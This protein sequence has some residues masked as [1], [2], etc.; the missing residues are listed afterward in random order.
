MRGRPSWPGRPPEP[1]RRNRSRQRSMPRPAAL[2]RLDAH[3]TSTKST[4]ASDR[5]AIVGKWCWTAPG[6]ILAAAATLRTVR[7]AVN[8]TDPSWTSRSQAAS[9]IRARAA[10]PGRVARWSPPLPLL[11]GRSWRVTVARHPD[12]Q[13]WTPVRRPLD[14]SQ[15]SGGSTRSRQRVDDRGDLKAGQPRPQA[16]VRSV[17]VDC[18]RHVEAERVGELGSIAVSGRPP[19]RHPVPG[20]DQLAVH[21]DV[22]GGGPTVVPESRTPSGASPR[23]PGRSDRSSRSLTQSSGRA[24]SAATPTAIV[25]RVVSVPAAT[26]SENSS[27]SSSGCRRRRPRGGLVVDLAVDRSRQEVAGSSRRAS[28]NVVPYSEHRGAGRDGTI[29]GPSEVVVVVVEGGVGPSD[30]AGPVLL[31]TPINDAAPAA[32]AR[33]PRA[34]AGRPRPLPPSGSAAATMPSDRLRMSARAIGSHE[35]TA[36]WEKGPEPLVV[37]VVGHVEQH[38]RSRRAGPR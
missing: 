20:P 2:D 18:L 12:R 25:L 38:T 10:R 22:D 8:G 32:A 4:M 37:R 15:L 16:E 31:G 13:V 1:P 34:P 3:P 29:R 24:A 7:P 21:I 30:E 36:Q 26:S 17:N 35:V 28:I 19:Q 23:P 6:D 33:Q 14:R 5:S 11:L 27:C 9:T